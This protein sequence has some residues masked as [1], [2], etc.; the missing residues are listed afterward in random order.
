LLHEQALAADGVQHLQEQGPEQLLRRDG[1]TT[2]MKSTCPERPGR[3]PVRPGSPSAELVLAD[4]PWVPGVPGTD[5][6]HGV[7]MNVVAPHGSCLPLACWAQIVV[8]HYLR[9]LKNSLATSVYRFVN[10][11]Y[12]GHAASL[13]NSC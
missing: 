13:I 12:S 10:S 8:F 9:Q 4:D 1:G 5:T 7:L 3:A 2:L 11:H 6:E